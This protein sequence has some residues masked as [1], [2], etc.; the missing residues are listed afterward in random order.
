MHD[1]LSFHA[2]RLGLNSS[3]ICVWHVNEVERDFQYA[4]FDHPSL[5][6]NRTV[7]FNYATNSNITHN[8]FFFNFNFNDPILV[9]HIMS[10]V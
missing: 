4:M 5:K 6:Y 2:Y 10:F 8:L 7:A 9:F 1:L 3:S